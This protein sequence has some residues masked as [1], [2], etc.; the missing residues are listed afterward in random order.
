MKVNMYKE[1]IIDSHFHSYGGKD[2]GCFIMELLEKSGLSAINIASLGNGL[3]FEDHFCNMEGLDIKKSNPGKIYFFG[4]LDYTDRSYMDGKVD[5]AE[6][7]RKLV[8]AGADGMKMLEGKPNVRK[9][10]G[11][12]IDSPVF[13]SYYRYMENNSLP[14]LMHIADPYEFWD[15]NKLPDWA[16]KCGAYW[17]DG[18]FQSKEQLYLETE[19]VL[20]KFPGLKI[21]LAHFFFMSADIDRASKFLDKW[22]SVS[23]DITPGDEMYHDFSKNS[24]DWRNFFIHY[25]DRI[26]FGTDNTPPEGDNY[27]NQLES[28]LNNIR[29]IRVFLETDNEMYSGKGLKLDN[30]VLEKIYRGNFLKSITH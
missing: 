29:K 14:I 22:G 7:A 12:P 9:A 13:D 15:I 16:R 23:F 17:G 27:Q 21:T 25:Q 26:I 19:G 10:M 4:A 5:F 8:E 3:P 20:K 11:L 18:S 6:Q 1:K 24:S 28:C 2:C 30:I